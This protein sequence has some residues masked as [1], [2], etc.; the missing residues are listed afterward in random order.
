M[1]SVAEQSS[2]EPESSSPSARQTRMSKSVQVVALYVG[3]FL[4]AVVISA[5]LVQATGGSATQVFGALL[6]GS[7]RAKGRWGQT[8][9]IAVPLVLVG[10]GTVINGRA[11]LINIGQEGQLYFGTAVACY[12]A[13]RLGGPGSAEWTQVFPGP[14]VLLACLAGGAVG[15]AFWAGIAGVLRYRRKVPEVLTTLLL[16]TVAAQVVGY[17]L[18]VEWLLM[19]PRDGKATA[20]RNI[21]AA[22][23]PPDRRMPQIELF[24]NEFPI[25][26]LIVVVGAVA[27]AVVLNRS[28]WGFRL[29]MLGHNPRTAHRA[30]VA[31]SRYGMAAILLSGGFAGLA[32][33]MMLTGGDFGNYH[34]TPG[35]SVNIGFDGL[36]V[37]LVARQRLL[38]VLPT[39]LVFAGLRTGSGFLAATGVERDLT[40]IVQSLLVLALLIPPAIFF[41]LD[42][43]RAMAA[44]KART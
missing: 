8:L 37:A 26:V 36:L 14:L 15:G 2:H 7:F 44:T 1:T 9:G 5:T 40:K 21:S 39:A 41:V 19:A 12:V 16:V 43:R 24:G 3:C 29:R 20:W 35:F 13:L 22:Q 30:G 6:D 33:A 42:R 4:A 23:L 32:G 18:R 38:I 27:V 31:E 17:A 28:I 11:G 34:L 25:S 10:M